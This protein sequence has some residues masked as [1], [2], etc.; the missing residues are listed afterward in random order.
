MYTHYYEL[1][2]PIDDESWKKICIDT[3]KVIKYYK[4]LNINVEANHP[5]GI[6]VSN[7]KKYINFFLL[8]KLYICCY[9]Y[10]K[11]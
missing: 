7:K 8:E 2:K 6:V 3:K 9:L 1:M 4:K 5:S 11:R 10:S